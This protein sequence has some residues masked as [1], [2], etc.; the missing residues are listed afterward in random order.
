MTVHNIASASGHGTMVGVSTFIPSTPLAL[1]EQIATLT[2][3]FPSVAVVAID[4]PDCAQPSRLAELVRAAVESHSRPSAVVS[5]HDYVR[6]ASL[7]YEFGHEDALSYRTIWFDYPA[8]DREVI[9]AARTKRAFLPKLWDEPTDRSARSTRVPV[10][11]RAVIVIAG[12]ML[13]GRGLEFDVSVRLDMSEPA[14]RRHTPEADLWTVDAL[15]EH[16]SEVSEEVDFEVRYD[17]P[18]RPA[19]R[20]RQ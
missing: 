2:G 14:M 6:P 20:S 13:L 15:L 12:P 18:A 4:G 17:H 19:V 7:R 1:A 11:E 9:T 8:L 3:S 16:R 10:H 5:L